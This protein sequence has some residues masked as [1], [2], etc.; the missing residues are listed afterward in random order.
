[1]FIFDTTS[2]MIFFSFMFLFPFSVPYIQPG[3]IRLNWSE[4][5][6]DTEWEKK[7][8]PCGEL[9]RNKVEKYLLLILNSPRM[10][11]CAFRQLWVWKAAPWHSN[12]YLL[13]SSHHVQ[14]IVL[15][16]EWL[17]V[18]TLERLKKVLCQIGEGCR[19]MGEEWGD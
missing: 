12:G 8:K 16:D 13:H 18:H 14:N 15:Q 9:D 19:G 2:H 6:P 1:M 3:E 5:V 10:I 7:R 17:T 11:E 4:T